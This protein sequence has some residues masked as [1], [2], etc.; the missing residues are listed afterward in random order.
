MA[1]RG[2]TFVMDAVTRD[3]ASFSALVLGLASSVVVH[4]GLDTQAPREPNLVLA[5]QS[6]DFIA[7]LREKTR[8][9]LTPEEMSV[10]DHVLADLRV[11]YVAIA[12]EQKRRPTTA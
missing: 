7:M 2:P 11:R 8:G 1:V 12:D 10:V 6:L 5:Q 9:N 3:T 4:L